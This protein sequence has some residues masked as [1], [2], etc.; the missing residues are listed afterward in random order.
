MFL[1]DLLPLFYE[2]ERVRKHIKKTKRSYITILCVF[3][4]FSCFLHIFF[5][6]TF[7]ICF[8]KI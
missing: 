2:F 7:I 1:N 5:D 8:M 6:A 4:G 3:H